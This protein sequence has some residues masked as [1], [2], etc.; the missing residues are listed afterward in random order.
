[1]S[2]QHRRSVFF[3]SLVMYTRAVA[4]VNFEAVLRKLFCKANHFSVAKNL[5]HYRGRRDNWLLCVAFNYCFLIRVFFRRT[6]SPV[7]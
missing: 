4:F 5:G 1:M 6:Q 7:E 3:Q 2:M